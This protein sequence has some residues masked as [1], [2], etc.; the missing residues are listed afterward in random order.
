LIR[1]KGE[2]PINATAPGLFTANGGGSG[3]PA[4]YALR[5]RGDAQIVEPLLRY[6]EGQKH[7][8]P[9]P[10]DLGTEG[11]LVFLVLFGTG[12]RFAMA[13]GV[14]ATVGGENAEVFYAGAAPGYDGVDQANV[15]LPRSLAGKGDV[16]ISLIA[17]N[18]SANAVTI[19][20]R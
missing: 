19:N 2:V 8:V 15:L 14:I 4:T 11:D 1:A 3:V 7:F 9:A 13:S 5:V 20:V 17:N 16:N 6:D 18:K 10:I 12:F